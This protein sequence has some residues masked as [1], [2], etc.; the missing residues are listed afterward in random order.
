MT[1]GYRYNREEMLEE[2]MNGGSG[3]EYINIRARVRG[4]VSYK[5]LVKETLRNARE[6]GE[7]MR[8]L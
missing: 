5:T 2:K 3:E 7:D 4:R 6:G 8:K 1:G